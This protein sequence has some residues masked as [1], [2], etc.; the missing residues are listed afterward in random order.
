MAQ[1]Q[2]LEACHSSGKSVAFSCFGSIRSTIS[3]IDARRKNVTRYDRPKKLGAASHLWVRMHMQFGFQVLLHVPFFFS[4]SISAIDLLIEF[5]P[6]EL[7][8]G[9]SRVVWRRK[10]ETINSRYWF[11]SGSNWLC[12]A[13]YFRMRNHFLT[14]IKPSELEFGISRNVWRRKFETINSIY[15]F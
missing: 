7:Q 15:W 2:L 9:I 14:E 6:S 4:N 8:F 1:K 5:E 13:A 3:T 12:S 11:K 10:F